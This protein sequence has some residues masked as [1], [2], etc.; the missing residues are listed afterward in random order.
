MGMVNVTGIVMSM[1][2]GV[3]LIAAMVL[4]RLL[5]RRETVV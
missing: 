2:I 4:P 1:L 5:K 3:L